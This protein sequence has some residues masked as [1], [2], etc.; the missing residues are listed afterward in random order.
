MRITFL[1]NRDLASN[2]AL[3]ILL[4][5][6]ASHDLSLLLSSRVGSA[7]PRPAALGEL[8]LFEQELLEQILPSL[9]T[10]SGGHDSRF[11][12]FPQMDHWLS[13]PGQELNTINSP[14]GLAL[15]QSLEPDLMVSIRYGVILREPAIAVPRLGVLNLHSGLLPDYRGVMASFW[16]LLRDEPVIGTTLHRITDSGIDQGDIIATTSL[17]VDP[18]K[19]YLWHVLG[20]YPEGCERILSAIDRLA[21]GQVPP[22]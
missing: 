6:L 14:E 10:G 22:G 16:A 21:S 4:P 17:A 1:A 13:T 2:L 20:L 12:T 18:G 3:N 11:R 7:A 5:R 9:N 8:A 15:L 19:S